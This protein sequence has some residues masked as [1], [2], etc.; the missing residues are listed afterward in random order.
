MSRKISGE[1]LT[2]KSDIV[3]VGWEK[4]TDV[5]LDQLQGAAEVWEDMGSVS[6]TNEDGMCNKH[7]NCDTCPAHKINVIVD[8]KKRKADI[9]DIVGIGKL[10]D[11]YILNT[12]ELLELI[13]YEVI[14]RKLF[15]T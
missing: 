1:K 7:D 15:I 13:E 4:L 11:N 2:S 14:Q 6:S 8:N 9:C 12:K 10:E 3:L 5:E